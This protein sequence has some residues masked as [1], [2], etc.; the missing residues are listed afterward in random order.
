MSNLT[1]IADVIYGLKVEYGETVVIGT[2]HYTIDQSTG[3]KTDAP[4][5]F[6]I[7]MAIPMPENLRE[8]FLRSIG[9]KREGYLAAG[10]RQFLV[11]KSDI[12]VGSSI[13]KN[14]GFVTFAGKTGDIQK[15]EDYL[16]AVIVTVQGLA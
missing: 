13:V 15:V 2:H 1:F 11:D 10:E 12:P 3:Q 16:Y 9:L 7:N 14:N 5:S 6:T 4:T 8:S